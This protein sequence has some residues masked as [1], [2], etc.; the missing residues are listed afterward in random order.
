MLRVFALSDKNYFT[1]CFV[2]FFTHRLAAL[3][4]EIPSGSVPARLAASTQANN[5][6]SRKSTPSEQTDTTMA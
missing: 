1:R 3:A 2:V 4:A 5:L 6:L